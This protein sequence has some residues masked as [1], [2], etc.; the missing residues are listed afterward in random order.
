MDTSDDAIL[1]RKFGEDVPSVTEL[2]KN[3]S[4]MLVNTH[5]SLNGPRPISPSVI[6]IGGAH[7]KEP[8]PLEKVN[9]S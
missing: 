9:I 3:L 6:E 5:Y 7:I 1:R 4:I 2:S 8:E